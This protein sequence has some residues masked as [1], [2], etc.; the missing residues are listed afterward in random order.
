MRKWHRWIGLVAGVF[1]V[2]TGF[3]GI[4][5]ECERFFGEE[6]ALRERLRDT[7]SKVSAQ[8]PNAEFAGQFARAQA[9]VAAKAGTQPLDKIT[10]QSRRAVRMRGRERLATRRMACPT[11]TACRHHKTFCIC[12]AT[13][14]TESILPSS[15]RTW[16]WIGF[17]EEKTRTRS[18]SGSTAFVELLV[19]ADRRH[20]VA[21]FDS[22]CE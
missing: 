16:R 7:I 11:S 9:A 17:G 15:A 3:T 4:W 2:L 21:I 22:D 6:E 10:R 18:C 14:R 8:S 13:A 19:R 20:G 1:F 12:C 5:L